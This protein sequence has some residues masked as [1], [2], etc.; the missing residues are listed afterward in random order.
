MTTFSELFTF[1]RSTGATRVNEDGL[2]VGV[3]FSSTSNTIGTGSKTF[4]LTA[5]ANVN[6]SWSVGEKV[7]AVSQAGATGSMTGTV[8]SY[9]ASTQTLVIDVTSIT[10]SGSS[11]D[12]R[13]GSLEFRYDH[14]PVTLAP[15]GG[16]VEGQATNT[17]FPSK[18]LTSAFYLLV[19]GAAT[20]NQTASEDGSVNASLFTENNVTGLH[21][22]RASNVGGFVPF[23]PYTVHAFVKPNGRRYLA[24][25]QG[26]D[27][28]SSASVVFDLQT[29]AVVNSGQFGSATLIG[30]GIT[31]VANGFY[32]IWNT[33]SVPSS[34]NFQV[35][36]LQQT[37]AIGSN[38]DATSQYIGD[39]V[40]GVFVGHMA[41][42]AGTKTSII[43]TTTVAV[44][45]SADLANID[46]SRFSDV[47]NQSQGTLYL[48]MTP[49]AGAVQ[50]VATSFND[51]SIDNEVRIGKKA[52]N[53]F[54]I[55]V[56]KDSNTEADLVLPT[57]LSG[58]KNKVAIRI[59][60]NNFA[61]SVNGSEPVIDNTTKIPLVNRLSVGM[62]GA[63]TMPLNGHIR[64]M[65]YYPVALND[66]QL[67]NL[68]V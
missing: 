51:G 1:S 27:A 63:Q 9:V 30:F 37:P 11:T 31:R 36:Y 7:V 54:D 48:E 58:Q 13:I 23:A 40:S 66:Q 53:T 42:Y 46:G 4:V 56:V 5:T 17:Y 26:S 15:K 39:G 44:T 8:T 14:N 29:G 24:L 19:N 21:A 68:T 10:G 50:A 59:K 6:R 32:E 60:P 18:N 67:K 35:F 61:A 62:S 38:M 49:I 33:A 65:I 3:D 25:F 47:Y 2:I 22:F 57:I 34:N 12:W 20:A 52:T 43:P 55:S 28:T 64:K 45:R 41:S 16:L